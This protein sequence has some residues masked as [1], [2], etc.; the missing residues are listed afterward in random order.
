MFGSACSL[1]LVVIQVPIVK[2]P[3][4][5]LGHCVACDSLVILLK[6]MV[7]DVIPLQ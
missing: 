3:T 7:G 2:I 1:N 6:S 4:V 5:L